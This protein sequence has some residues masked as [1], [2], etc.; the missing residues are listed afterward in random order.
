MSI[1]LTSAAMR[2][3]ILRHATSSG[4][5]PLMTI[6]WDDGVHSGVLRFAMHDED[7]VSR[8]L[9]FTARSFR[10]Q[11]PS[12]DP[13]EETPYAQIVADGVDQAIRVEL[14]QLTAAATCLLE[15]VDIENVDN[16]ESS[17]EGDI[18]RAR[19][20]GTTILLEFKPYNDM[21]NIPYPGYR[22]TKAFGFNAIR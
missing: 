1:R 5:L 2:K 18:E 4:L 19:I 7:V 17:V 13:D 22:M 9:T 14:R 12:E 11:L 10:I 6:T 3:N 20:K 21:A 15:L 16:V 8:S